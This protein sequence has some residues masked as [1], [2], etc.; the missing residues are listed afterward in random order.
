MRSAPIFIVRGFGWR[1]R[2]GQK[3]LFW[4][5]QRKDRYEWGRNQHTR[6]A[7]PNQRLTQHSS[8]RIFISGRGRRLA[9]WRCCSGGEIKGQASSWGGWW[10]EHVFRQSESITVIYEAS[11]RRRGHFPSISRGRECGGKPPALSP[12]TASGW[13]ARL[14]LARTVPRARR[15]QGAM[16]W[17]L[18]HAVR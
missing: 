4:C 14:A 6:K 17:V 10:Q 1:S 16:L 18:P 8:R 12:T 11:S 13:P 15:E 2:T 9:A 5:I 7:R 3:R